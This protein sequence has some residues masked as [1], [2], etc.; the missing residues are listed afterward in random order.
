MGK[1]L[2]TFDLIILLLEIYPK[3]TI[4]YS[5]KD[6]YTKMYTEEL[7]KIEKLRTPQMS[8]HGGMDEK[9]MRWKGKG[10]NFGVRGPR[11]VLWSFCY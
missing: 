10:M 2:I 7:L 3:E 1:M 6:L 5:N 8:N 4:Y 11:L 9:I